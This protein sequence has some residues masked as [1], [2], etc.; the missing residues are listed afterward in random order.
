MAAPITGFYAGVLGLFILGLALR[1]VLARRASAIGLGDGGDETLRRR[2]RI[3]GNATEYVPLAL[4]LMLMAEV[5]GSSPATMHAL[6]GSL[7]LG[8]LAHA[9]GLTQSSGDSP[10]R[11]IGNT[12]TWLSIAAASVILISKFVG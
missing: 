10:G 3:H 12:L 11:L 9:Q 1:V 8:R 6:G 7:T 5:G 2:I 4:L